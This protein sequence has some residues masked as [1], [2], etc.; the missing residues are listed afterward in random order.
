MDWRLFLIIIPI[1]MLIIY[2]YLHKHCRCSH[3]KEITW[4]KELLNNNGMCSMCREFVDKLEYNRRLTADLQRTIA[5]LHMNI[6][7]SDE[8]VKEEPIIKKKKV[9]IDK[10]KESYD[11]IM[12][13]LRGM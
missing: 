4:R 3:C 2:W 9:E 12:K 11:D 5:H 1:I 8:E 13:E 10:E 7:N 6:E